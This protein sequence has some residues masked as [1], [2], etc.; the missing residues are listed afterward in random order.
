MSRALVVFEVVGGPTHAFGLSRPSTRRDATGRREHPPVPPGIGVREWLALL[1]GATGRRGAAFGTRMGASGLPGSAARAVH[2]RL[3]R[4]GLVP[5]GPPHSFRVA[6][7]D[8]PLAD[9]EQARAKAWGDELG[10]V[11]AAALRGAR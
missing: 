4:L 6:G 10:V 2:R 11:L 8:G 3:R 5:M 7:M 1:E 9:G